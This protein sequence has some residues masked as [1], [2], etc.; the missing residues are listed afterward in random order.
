MGICFGDILPVARDRYPNRNIVIQI[1]SSR[2]PS[3]IL[4]A[5]NGGVAILDLVADADLFTDSNEKIGTIRIEGTFEVQIQTSGN[6]LTGHGEITNLRL[7]NPDQ[8]LGLSQ[9]AL[10]NLGNLGKELVGKAANDVLQRGIPIQIPSGAGGL[11]LNF[12]APEFKIVEHAIYLESDF[13]ISPS[14][15]AQLTGGGGGGGYGG[16]CRR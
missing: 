15:I 13:T 12:V 14:F 8:S 7:T 2:A 6:R 4:S 5:R 10:D 9:E 3:V 1:H 11:P 16:V